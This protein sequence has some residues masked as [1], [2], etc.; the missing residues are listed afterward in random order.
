[1]RL[2][3]LKGSFFR[4]FGNTPTISLDA[5][6]VIIFGPNGSGKTSIA[7]SLEWLFFGTTRR[8]IRAEVD[9]VEYRGH[10]QNVACPDGCDPFV[11]LEVRLD[12]GKIHRLRRVLHI[13]GVMERTT[14]YLDDIEVHN[15]STIGLENSEHFYPIVVQHNL[16]EL[17]LST[18]TK[19][20]QF[21]SRLL[22]LGPLLAYDRALDSAIDR[23]ENSLPRDIYDKFSEFK[24]LRN[25]LGQKAALEDIVNRWNSDDVRYPSDWDQ[26]LQYIQTKLEMPAAAIDAIKAQASKNVDDAKKAVFDINPFGPKKD[27]VDHSKKFDTELIGFRTSFDHLRQA[28]S[29]YASVRSTIYGQLKFSLD[30]RRLKLWREGLVFI[31]IEAIPDNQAFQCPFCEEFTITKDKAKTIK[32]RLEATDQY[33]QTRKHLEETIES[34]KTHLVNIET[35][36]EP[37]LTKKLDEESRNNLFKLLP[38]KGNEIQE[39]SRSINGLYSQQD[40]LKTKL[41]EIRVGL[42]QLMAMLDDPFKVTEVENLFQNAEKDLTTSTNTFKE[43]VKT[44]YQNYELILRCLQPVLGSSEL[45][46]ERQFIET[47]SNAQECVKVSSQILSTLK[48]LREARQAVRDYLKQQDI[49]RI[50]DR[51]KDIGKWFN[52]LYGCSDQGVTFDSVD[53]SGTVMRIL[54]SIFGEKRHASTHMSQSQLNCLGLAMHIVGTTWQDSPFKFILFDDPIQSFDDDHIESFKSSLI[55]KLIEEYQRQ[56]IVMTHIEKQVADSIR[57]QH[58]HRNPIYYHLSSYGRNGLTLRERVPIKDEL[59][60]LQGQ[61]T[62]SSDQIRMDCRRGIRILCEK[63]V[64]ELYRHELRTEIPKEYQGSD[65]TWNQVKRLCLQ[66]PSM[67]TQ[68]ITSLDDTCSFCD[69]E[70]HDDTCSQAPTQAQL[71]PHIDRLLTFAKKKEIFS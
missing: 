56:V 15:F 20:R 66:I 11:E 48:D 34:C 40:L 57:N 69:P 13:E 8:R 2:V 21:I 51:G 28:T 64:K 52:L 10:L 44:H 37:F 60:V 43:A 58:R 29:N 7:E 26:I 22:G 16:Q 14:T 62:A 12:N 31:D 46:Q 45:V 24:R 35:T 61:A 23:F 17:I 19:R 42:D 30:P 55:T 4:G 59:K 3:N 68:E 53:P 67:T 25:S 18:G 41:Q 49:S 63:I 54:A 1:M 71:T 5:P 36:C 6:L 50:K 9:E 27:F 65:V 70:H 33:S 47:L 38:T 39:F 32:G